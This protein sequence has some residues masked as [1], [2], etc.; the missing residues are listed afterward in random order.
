MP[1]RDAHRS[2]T[3]LTLLVFLWGAVALLVDP[4]QPFGLKNAIQ[5]IV[6][7]ALLVYLVR[8]WRHP[9]RRAAET[10]SALL[11]GYTLLLLPWLIIEWCRLGRPVDAFFLP[12][13]AAV[14]MALVFPG[15]L[16]LGVA[17]MCLFAAESMF[18]FVY[19]RYLGLEELIPV[20]EPFATFAF[21]MLGVALFT[22]RHRRRQLAE[23]YVRARAEIEALDRVRP[24][25]AR[26]RAALEEQLAILAAEA[27]G[28]GG[29]RRDTTRSAVGRALDRLDDLRGRLG[30][31]SI[32]EGARATSTASERQL[33]AHDAQLGA[34]ILSGLIAT[35]AIPALLMAFRVRGDVPVAMAAQFC[36]AVLMFVYVAVTRHRPSSRRALWAVI[37]VVV[38]QLPAIAH[39][40]TWMLALDRPF[41]PLVGHKL[42]M[43]VL[44][45]TL[46]TR[47]KLGVVL[48]SVIAANAIVLWFALDFGAYRDNIALG[49]PIN[50]LVYLLIGIGSLRMLEQREIASVRLLRAR[51]DVSAMH[52]R[53]R[54][55][56][57]LRDR[58]NSP[59]QTLVLGEPAATLHLPDERAR[60]VQDA[61]DRLVA[62][63]HELAELDTLVPDSGMSLDPDHELRRHV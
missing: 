8:S 44:G 18:A 17:A 24:Q 54:M 11:I 45:L 16:W 36:V 42:L 5:S 61:I 29:D 56:L 26:A 57:A 51:A 19:A 28:D 7:A 10:I 49:E 32:A 9:R 25:L 35:L 60:R 47:F 63:S 53:A 20:T 22:L 1:A 14:S 55:F 39:N 3:M 23:L 2:A 50:T 59:L 46:A 58:L 34:I 31:L 38:C 27:V 15:R 40:Q 43:G 41:T 62:L 37:I 4:W 33:L 12:Q 52:R 6:A 48:I 13:V 30:S 21:L